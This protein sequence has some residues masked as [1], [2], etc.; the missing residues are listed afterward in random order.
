MPVASDALCK[1]TLM[2]L[3]SRHI[4][5][6][7][8]GKLLKDSGSSEGKGRGQVST[9]RMGCRQGRT[10]CSACLAVLFL[11]PPH[12]LPQWW[13]G[14][15][16]GLDRRASI[17]P[18]ESLRAAPQPEG[19]TNSLIILHAFHPHLGWAAYAGQCR[20]HQ[21]WPGQE[22]RCHQPGGGRT[23][24]LWIRTVWF[25]VPSPSV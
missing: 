24:V 9:L 2:R 25:G 6:S 4:N 12:Q 21:V 17:S 22:W 19:L 8:V 7:L 13:W 15:E 1:W 3:Q 23:H 11:P 18:S 5:T 20:W 16:E 14:P 10:L